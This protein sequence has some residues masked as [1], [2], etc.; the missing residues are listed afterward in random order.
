MPDAEDR[1]KKICALDKKIEKLCEN[2]R[3]TV[4]AGKQHDYIKTDDI[5]EK[6]LDEIQAIQRRARPSILDDDSL[7]S[8]RE[9]RQRIDSKLALKQEKAG[10]KDFWWTP[11]G[12][13][14][15]ER[16]LVD[17]LKVVDKE[18]TQPP[19][20]VVMPYV[21]Q[22]VKD[23]VYLAVIVSLLLSAHSQFEL[24]VLAILMLIYSNLTYSM[25]SVAHTTTAVVKA[26]DG[27]LGRIG[28]AL[29][30]MWLK[31]Q[32]TDSRKDEIIMVIHT[33]AIGLGSLCGT[34]GLV[35]SFFYN[36]Q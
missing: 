33:V 12:F 23:L 26:L 34:I 21:W 9:F 31:P 25:I 32:D 15:T 7:E 36:P 29:R 8:L 10:E 1:M 11:P 16:L 3:A 20:R 35:A 18:L 14:T 5:K 24:R 6:L 4:E 27:E 17:V 19:K 13:E 2:C 28:R 30:L 22:V